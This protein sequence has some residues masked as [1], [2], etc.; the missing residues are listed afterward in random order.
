MR[1]S[2]A[3]CRSEPTRSCPGP[4]RFISRRVQFATLASRHA[5]PAIYYVRDFVEAGGLMSYGASNIVLSRLGIIAAGVGKGVAD[6]EHV[7]VVEIDPAAT[8]STR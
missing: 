7:G 8:R 3:W 1:L 4:T 5:L 6:V 2:T